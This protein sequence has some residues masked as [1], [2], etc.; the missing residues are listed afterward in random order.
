MTEMLSFEW[1]CRWQGDSEETT[2][3][4]NTMHL[5]LVDRHATWPPQISYPHSSYFWVFGPSHMKSWHGD[6]Y[7]FR[8]TYFQVQSV[9]FS[10][11][12]NGEIMSCSIF[13]FSRPHIFAFA[14]CSRGERAIEG[15]VVAYFSVT[16]EEAYILSLAATQMQSHSYV[17]EALLLSSSFEFSFSF[18]GSPGSGAWAF[19]T[20]R[21]TLGMAT[22][23]WHTC[24]VIQEKEI[25]QLYPTFWRSFENSCHF[26]E[27]TRGQE[28]HEGG[29]ISIRSARGRANIPCWGV[30]F[31]RSEPHMRQTWTIWEYILGLCSFKNG[32]GE[33]EQDIALLKV[34]IGVA[35][36][37]NTHLHIFMSFLGR[38]GHIDHLDPSFFL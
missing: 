25:R 11:E 22:S 20:G 14:A 31:R 26:L 9:V 24:V 8:I 21:D 29:H 34:D 27:N 17:C 37:T 23:F 12:D 2:L 7:F 6:F 4:H 28:K 16:E 30:A 1:D 36:K 3:L 18:H 33:D 32:W 5:L 38:H 35:R 10:N 15:W 13:S 19:C